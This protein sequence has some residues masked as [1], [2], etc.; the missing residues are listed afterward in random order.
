M[1]YQMQIPQEVIDEIKDHYN[2]GRGSLQDYARLYNVPM[3]KVLEITGNTGLSEVEM[4]GD[5]VDQ[6][7][8]GRSG[9]VNPG[10]IIDTPFDLS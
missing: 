8:L 2:N 7:E 9:T 4:V 10:E 6:E 3:Q 1:V 5:Q